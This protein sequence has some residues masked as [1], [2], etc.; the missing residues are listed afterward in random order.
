MIETM[1]VTPTFYGDTEL[2]QYPDLTTEYV[3]EYKAAFFYMNSAA[4]PC[5]SPKLLRSIK[6]FFSD[7]T[8]TQKNG[9]GPDIHYLVLASKNPGIFNLGGDLSVIKECVLNKD[10]AGLYEYALSCIDVLHQ[11]ISGLD[12]GL[13]TI[14]LVQGDALGGGLEAALSS[15]Y[16]IAERG[17]KLG[18]PESIFNL[19][20]GMGAFNLL[21][22]R[23]GLKH[24]RELIIEGRLHTSDEL[25]ELGVI[26]ELIE[27]G[28]GVDA[29]YKHIKKAERKSSSYNFLNKMQQKYH[30]IEF[31]ELE[32]IIQDWVD[33]AFSN[34]TKE[35]LKMMTLLRTRQ[36][37]RRK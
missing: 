21:S 8:Y 28:M 18:F 17:V 3:Q 25:F 33:C 34:I 4:V 31:K 6:K 15:D 35:N 7:L 37:N 23:I 13:K 30:P 12:I 26:D 29:V 9:T 16:I 14:S 10:R 2:K 22:R 11:N 5:F 24:I 36:Q 27:P 20:P 1:V 19:Y 32:E